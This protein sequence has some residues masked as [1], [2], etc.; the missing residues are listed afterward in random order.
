MLRRLQ[1]RCGRVVTPNVRISEPDQTEQLA[2][3]LVISQ[4]MRRADLT[5]DGERLR[6]YLFA[7]E[8]LL[9][10]DGSANRCNTLA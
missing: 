3:L 1:R 7:L 6:S 8:L 10:L 2:F 4:K 5:P 9:S